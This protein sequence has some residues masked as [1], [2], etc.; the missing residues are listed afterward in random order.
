MITTALNGLFISSTTLASGI[1]GGT[2]FATAAS[3]FELTD[4][5]RNLVGPVGF[6]A[7]GSAVLIWLV[8]RLKSADERELRRTAQ[9]DETIRTLVELGLASNSAIERSTDLLLRVAKAVEGCPG[10][11]P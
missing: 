6:M 4:I 8:A 10:R 3:A 7:F 5:E 11:K 9:H 1:L 2:L